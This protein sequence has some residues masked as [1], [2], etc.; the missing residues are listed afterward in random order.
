[1][2]QYYE[3]ELAYLKDAYLAEMETE[4][5]GI[6]QDEEGTL[7]YLDAT[8]FYPEGGGQP[9]DTGRI[10]GE[11]GTANITHARYSQGVVAH[12][13]ELEGSLAVGDRVKCLLDWDTRYRHMRAHSAGHVLHDALMTL[14]H[15]E[16]LFP[17]KGNHK[18]LYVDYSG[19]PLLADLAGELERKCNEIIAANLALHVRMVDLAELRQVCDFV[20]TNLPTDKPLRILSIEGFNPMPCGGTHVHRAGEIGLMK[21][22][23]INLK[24][25]VNHIKYQIENPPL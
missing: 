23:A 4:I 11:H 2:T 24:K 9:S 12:C 7:V 8:I 22:T 1:M 18:K 20:P 25:G 15:P 3:T 21:I 16:N 19:D 6:D 17:L 10:I 14:P 13:S 5:I